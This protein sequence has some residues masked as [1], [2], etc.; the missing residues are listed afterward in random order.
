MLTPRDVLWAWGQD[1]TLS[2]EQAA[3][4]QNLQR[5]YQLRSIGPTPKRLQ[6]LLHELRQRADAKSDQ[7]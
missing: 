5:Y 4:A 6:I 7:D 3:I 1:G 2:P